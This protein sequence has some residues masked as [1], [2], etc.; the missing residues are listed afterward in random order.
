MDHPINGLIERI[1][2]GAL[3]S[4]SELYSAYASLVRSV[5][6]KLCQPQE[7]DDLVQEVFVKIWKGLPKFRQGSQLKTWIYRVAYNSAVDALRKKKVFFEELDE[8]IAEKEPKEDRFCREMI[9]K[10]LSKLT[11]EHRTVLVLCC[12]E[13]LTVEE[14]AEVTKAPVGTVKSRLHYAKAN[15]HEILKREGITL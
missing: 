5:I 3:K 12:L 4:F 1:S 8:G 2:G 13:E 11:E 6:Y 14:A 7:L 9:L 15:L 10:G